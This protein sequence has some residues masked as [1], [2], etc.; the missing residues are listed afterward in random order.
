MN[1]I[2]PLFLPTHLNNEIQI[3]PAISIN[4]S[5][6]PIPRRSSLSFDND[7]ENNI[8]CELKND[9]FNA[10]LFVP[11]LLINDTKLSDKQKYS[12]LTTLYINFIII[13][14]M[15]LILPNFTSYYLLNQLIKKEKSIFSLD[16]NIIIIITT[17]VI[18]LIYI[19]NQFYNSFK[20]T[21]FWKKNVVY[22]DIWSFNCVNV[23]GNAVKIMYMS[24]PQWNTR[25]RFISV[26][27]IQILIKISLI[28]AGLLILITDRENY[29]DTIK[30]CLAIIFI[31]DT[32]EAVFQY[33]LN[34]NSNLKQIWKNCTLISN[35][36]HKDSNSVKIWKN[37]RSTLVFPVLI[38]IIALVFF[39]TVFYF[40]IK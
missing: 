18:F 2:S 10:V 15:T 8:K 28:F 21:L 24:S 37:F 23:S 36:E 31:M 1:R 9:I 29:I 16:Y 7:Y 30:D 11:Y 6:S 34:L 20:P 33:Y 25:I 26:C 35:K 40:A 22:S 19:I 4:P 38:I 27:I 5:I 12:I 14:P 13:V 32:D 39:K 17:S 3:S